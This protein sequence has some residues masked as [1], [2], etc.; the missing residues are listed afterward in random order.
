VI[1]GEDQ[2]ERRRGGV[3][4]PIGQRH[5]LAVALDQLQRDSLSICRSPRLG[6]LVRGDVDA[7]HLGSRPRGAE[8]DTTRPG[9]DVEQAVARL[10]RELVDD[11]VVDRGER[12]RDTLVVRPAPAGG[13]VAQ[14]CPSIARFVSS[15][16][17]FHSSG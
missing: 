12:L 7:D 10:Q 14:A 16:R 2:P 13:S 9:R 4:A 3:K 1:R 6:E 11:P 15:V 8:S 5:L 17:T